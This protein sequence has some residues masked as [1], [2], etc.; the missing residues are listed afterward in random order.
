MPTL[1]YQPQK[2]RLSNCIWKMSSHHSLTVVFECK[3]EK[4]RLEP[5]YRRLSARNVAVLW[6]F[7]F[8]VQKT[9]CQKSR[10]RPSA[11]TVP[12]TGSAARRLCQCRGTASQNPLA[13]RPPPCPAARNMETCPWWCLWSRRRS[14]SPLLVGGKYHVIPERNARVNERGAVQLVFWLAAKASK[15]KTSGRRLKPAKLRAS[16]A[17]FSSL[18]SKCFTVLQVSEKTHQGHF[19]HIHIP[20]SL[21]LQCAPQKTKSRIDFILSCSLSRWH[22]AHNCRRQCWTFMQ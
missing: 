16:M 10:L 3:N 13:R 1:Q 9:C 2:C 14:S 15:W 4:K 20:M 6:Y 19:Q 11:A 8:L 5:K 7:L 21:C 12:R 17:K 18:F 22:S